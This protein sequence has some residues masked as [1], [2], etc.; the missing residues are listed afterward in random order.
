MTSRARL[1][2]TPVVAGLAVW[3][4]AA[5][6]P[7]APPMPGGT[8]VARF[9]G[10]SEAAALIRAFTQTGFFGFTRF[11]PVGGLR[12]NAR[13]IEAS[14]PFSCDPNEIWRVAVVVTQGDAVAKGKT[15]GFCSGNVGTWHALAV[16]RGPNGFAAGPA[17]GCGRLSTHA[18]SETTDSFEWCD[19]FVLESTS[20]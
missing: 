18:G 4:L 3:A 5:I 1:L 14:G 19:E 15:Q 11:N 9:G 20:E 7:S 16:A 10:P 2:A 12:A 8:L 13:L 6:L 17:Q